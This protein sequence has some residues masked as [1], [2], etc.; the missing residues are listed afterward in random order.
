M[1]ANS[2]ATEATDWGVHVNEC[3]AFATRTGADWWALFWSRHATTGRLTDLGQSIAG[4]LW[5]VA[6]DT[7][8]DAES[9]REHMVTQGVPASAVAVRRLAKCKRV[10]A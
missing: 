8:E 1:T 9:L 3:A 4:G 6:C 10:G 2:A 5:H 7:K